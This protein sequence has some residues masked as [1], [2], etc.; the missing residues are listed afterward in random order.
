MKN[1]YDEFIPQKES[2]KSTTPIKKEPEKTKNHETHEYD[3]IRVPI[4]K[5][6][7]IS[8]L[9]EEIQVNKIAIEHKNIKTFINDLSVL[10]HALQE[11]VGQLR[12]IPVGNL[13]CTFPRYVR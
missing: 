2:I 7:K 5:I 4:H 9:L 8:S 11:E 3:S 1:A 6:E 10:L 13:L 12:M